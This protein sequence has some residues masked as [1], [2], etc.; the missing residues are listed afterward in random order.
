MEKIITL[1]YCDD[2]GK[3]IH[4]NER[5]F[6]IAIKRLNTVRTYTLMCAECLT[7]RVAHSMVVEPD[8]KCPKCFGIVKNCTYCNGEGRKQ[9]I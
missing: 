7:L 2:C 1:Y 3:Q 8:I 6:S 9:L 4:D 5:H